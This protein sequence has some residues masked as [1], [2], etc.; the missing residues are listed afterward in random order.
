MGHTHTFTHFQ[1]RAQ[2]H[3][4]QGDVQVC[5]RLR[6]EAKKLSSGIWIFVRC[7]LAH[8]F[9]LNQK[10]LGKHKHGWV[11]LS[12]GAGVGTDFLFLSVSLPACELDPSFLVINNNRVKCL[13]V[14]WRK[15][16]PW[17]TRS[18]LATISS[19]E[20]YWRGLL[21]LNA[22]LGWRR[23]KGEIYRGSGFGLIQLISVLL[24]YN[25]SGLFLKGKLQGEKEMGWRN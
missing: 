9:L 14:S 6:V 7:S 11:M 12:H 24:H 3:R 18:N 17:R 15:S 16:S 1:R 19:E 2:T 10:E 8:N 25:H 13:L 22:A 5:E 21:C 4:L 23:D 20:K